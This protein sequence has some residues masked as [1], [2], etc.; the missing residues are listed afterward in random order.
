MSSV[1]GNSSFLPFFLTIDR[2]S[3]QYMAVSKRNGFV[4]FRQPVILHVFVRTQTTSANMTFHETHEIGSWTDHDTFLA[5]N[6]HM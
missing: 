4:L 6:P 2:L 5:Y 1:P 3:I